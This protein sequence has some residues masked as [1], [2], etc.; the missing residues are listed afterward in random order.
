MKLYNC[1][2]VQIPYLY[3]RCGKKFIKLVKVSC[4]NFE[5][6]LT[7]GAKLPSIQ[8]RTV[9]LYILEVQWDL[10]I[11]K[12]QYTNSLNDRIAII[13][14]IKLLLQKIPTFK[15]LHEICDNFPV[16]CRCQVKMAVVTKQPALRTKNW[17]FLLS[18]QHNLIRQMYQGTLFTRRP[19]ISYLVLL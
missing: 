5:L 18:G 12:L 7:N 11:H 16:A 2:H 13:I 8:N 4:T 19:D 1:T 3:L 17:S 14:T 9:K 15:E 10:S 6:Q